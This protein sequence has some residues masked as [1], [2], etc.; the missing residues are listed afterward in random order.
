MIVFQNKIIYMPSMPPFSRSEKVVD[1]A[2]Q[3]KPVVWVE[4]GIQSLDGTKLVLLEG[5]VPWDKALAPRKHIVVVYFQGNG[6]SLPP[7][8]PYISNIL[9]LLRPLEADVQYTVVALSYRGFWKSRGRPSQSGIEL[10]AQAALQWVSK[11]YEQMQNVVLVLWGQSIG[12]GVA[13]IAA[14]AQ[15]DRNQRLKP[16]GKD[17]STGLRVSGLLLETPF[18]SLR[19]MLIALYPQKLL[20][21]RYLGPFLV[22]TWDSE[23]ALSA[24]GNDLN[25]DRAKGHDDVVERKEWPSM[26]VLLLEAGDDELVPR[27]DAAKLK[28]I[29][30][31]SKGFSVEHKVIS[32]ALHTD[33]MMKGQGKKQISQFLQGFRD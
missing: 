3:C 15:M 29:C 25:E 1:Y 5:A 24:I 22:S 31:R 12:T 10:D 28:D 21:Y 20:P 23:A 9:K 7:R 6:S 2:S 14:A 13:T 4:H 19:A 18:T 32:G 17:Q 27:G 30:E 26:R 16:E 33:V 11:R 8:L